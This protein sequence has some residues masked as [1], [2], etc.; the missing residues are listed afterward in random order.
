MTRPAHKATQIADEANASHN[1]DSI[2]RQLEMNA[3]TRRRA[4]DFA[5]RWFG[6]C[7]VKFLT[8]PAG[9]SLEFAKRI[10]GNCL[11]DEERIR[12][13]IY[14]IDGTDRISDDL[15]VE[16]ESV[17]ADILSGVRQHG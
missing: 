9:A 8:R 16:A 13:A 5:V 12:L 17:L 6:A 7:P 4:H 10:A 14:L 11:N 15:R 1:L 2:T 3:D